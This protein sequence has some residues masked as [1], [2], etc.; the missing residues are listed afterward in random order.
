MVRYR[1]I[2]MNH[3]K[4]QPGGGANDDRVNVNEIRLRF[5]PQMKINEHW[6]G[7]ARIDY[8]NSQDM[9]TG[10]NIQGNDV[11]VDRIWVAGDYKNLKIDL[12][13]MGYKTMA[14]GGLLIN[15]TLAGGRVVFGNDIQVS[16]AIGR[17]N[18]SW[19]KIG[20]SYAL[21]ANVPAGLL[22][23]AED[24]AS[25]YGAIEVY[26]NRK[27]KFT[28]GIG[29][30]RIGTREFERQLGM[31]SDN[32]SLLGVGL[33]YKFTPQV[34]LTAAWTHAFGADLK[35]PNAADIKSQQKN[36]WAFQ[37]N[38]MGA[39]PKKVN[40][41]GAYVAFRQIGLVSSA[42][43]NEYSLTGPQYA[44]SRGFELGASWA[45]MKN[46]VG[47]VKWFT[48]KDMEFQA[49]DGNDLK[50]NTIFTEWNFLF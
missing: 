15:R 14:D 21:K 30:H 27:N 34:N 13:M 37:L 39:D 20:A 38:Y 25:T 8:Y 35:D 41:W 48:G 11:K 9:N 29:Y 10:A 45:P 18:N 26:N 42:G 40:S 32:Y 47:C 24:K 12:G 46:V 19:D 50:V 33:G 5:E 7:K 4:G 28:W 3:E 6:T 22:D 16:L 49:N 43:W 2:H 23:N 36:S 17:M 1:Y 44:G 31:D